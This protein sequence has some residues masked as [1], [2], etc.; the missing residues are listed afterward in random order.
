[1][2]ERKLDWNL[3]KRLLPYL[4][5]YWFLAV[6]SVALM[7]L[8]G[9]VSVLHPYLIKYGIDQN[10]SKGDVPG[11][12]RTAFL[13][14][15]VMLASFVI[16]VLFEYTVQFLGQRMLL[17]LRLDLFRHVLALSREY[18]D[19]TSVGNT[20]TNITNDVEAIR[21]FV[22][23]GVVTVIG[24]L[25]KVGFILLAMMLVNYKLALLTF[26]TLPFF[27]I[28]TMLFRKSIR[29]GFRG[30]R[31][32]NADINTSLVET[33]TGI[34]EIIQFT[35][36]DKSKASF[37]SSNRHY[38]EAYLRVVHAYALYFPILEIVSNA[39]LLIILWYAHTSIGI[40]VKVGEIFAVFAY[41]NM[42]FRPLRELAE[43]FNMFQSAMA[44]S[45]RV[46]HLL[47]TK[48]AV[49]SP[50]FPKPVPPQFAGRIEFRDVTFA[51]N[52]ETPVLRNVSFT[53]E[54]GERVALVGFTGSGK[55]TIINLI[56]RFYDIQQGSI[57]VDGVDIREYSLQDLRKQ[58][59]VVPQDP[60]L[61]T[62]TIGQNISL[63]DRELTIEEI[64]QAA[65]KVSA[66]EFIK[67][68]PRQYDEE[69]LEEGKKLSVG[70]KQLLSFARAVVRNP[71]ILIL[72]EATSSIDSP[73]EKH[74]EAATRE[75][76]SRRTSIVI[77]HRLST[78]QAVDRI[79]VLHKGRLAEVGTHRELM[80]LEGIYCR[81]YK[82]QAMSLV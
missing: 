27:F 14:L 17:D 37:E 70:Q 22:S 29:T 33:I 10:I 28:A 30:V 2:V 81:L 59:A 24:E 54:P 77:A 26:L 21:A 74:I 34:R 16:S 40:S 45:E 44:A 52:P 64:R 39:S 25:L 82:T 6:S 72:D 43:K 32:A 18:F 38:L 56:N 66:H 12:W 67:A 68:L 47:D 23:E 75:L 4:R 53:I 69:V 62:G 57:L 11:L 7:V 8:T 41:I 42:F 13:L 20:L 80:A 5:N 1:M 35:H 15:G 3:L 65:H 63:H 55:T 76:I 71:S 58:I 50:S 60:F 79:L 61:F 36:K 51:Y 73:T 49:T 9:I 78:I 48:S 31:R 19:R 46:F